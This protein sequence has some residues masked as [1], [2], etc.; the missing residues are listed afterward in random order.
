[1]TKSG[2]V[3][4]GIGGWT[5]EAWRDHF[6]PGDLKQK[7]EL[8]YASRQLKVIEINGTYYSSQK[9]ETF[10]KWAADVPDGFI[11]SLKASRFVTNRRVLAEAGESMERF[12]TQ[13]LTELGPH[14]G[15]ILWQFA[16]TKKFDPDDFE[17]FLKLLPAKQ[18]GLPLRHVVEVRHDSFKVP[19]FVALLEKYA[20]APV[21]AEH[22]DYPMIADVTAD[23]V[24]ARLQ[25]GSDEIKT[26]YAPSD[27]KA[28]AT[29]LE[30]WA[31]GKVP[32]D[33]PL[34]D[35]E[36]QVAAEPRDVFA[37]MIHEGKV[38][39]PFGAMALQE[40]VSR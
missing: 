19:E 4:V 13:G 22:F 11:F 3:R 14:L 16:P 21:V 8:H 5:F 39:A 32:G 9:P 25:Q 38:N 37:F 28:W 34:I 2:N 12:L 36:R 15:P 20:V 1:M 40:A 23:F 18:D 33:L 26:C 27:L 35:G 10:A 24:Y 30:T 31:D 17:G 6:Y 7:D 29:R